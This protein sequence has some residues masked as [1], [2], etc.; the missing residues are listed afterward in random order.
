MAS[1]WRP[2]MSRGAIRGRATCIYNY[3]VPPDPA[4]L[5]LLSLL[6]GDTV[7]IL[8]ETDDWYY[9]HTL[10]SVKGLFPKSYVYFNENDV[11][12]EP[13]VAETNAT[14]KEWY[15]ILKEKF[16]TDDLTTVKEIKGI[17][18]E[19]SS[20][21]SQLATMKLTVEMAKQTREK[22]ITK[23]DFLN[24]SLKLDLVVRDANAV[25]LEPESTSAVS[26]F[27]SHVK[28]ANSCNKFEAV[29]IRHRSKQ[30]N[31]VGTNSFRIMLQMKSFDSPKITED[32]D[33]IIG[34]YDVVSVAG[35]LKVTP[36]CETF[37]I[38]N[39]KKNG[40]NEEKERRV[41]FG[42]L[43]KNDISNLDKNHR[44]FLIC[45]VVSYGNYGKYLGPGVELQ[46]TKNF[47][48]PIGV[49]ASDI[50]G[51]FTFNLGTQQQDKNIDCNFLE[52]DE[53]ETLFTTF[54]RFDSDNKSTKFVPNVLQVQLG[55]FYDSADNSSANEHQFGAGHLL[56]AKKLG[57]PE[58]IF[59]SDVRNDLYINILHGE[60]GR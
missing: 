28:S 41:Q 59:P 36:I 27:R 20:F 33:L 34:I 50:T 21:R 2:M 39:W 45:N 30:E 48:K 3:N 54:K 46:N 35:E 13:L 52:G 22:I 31:S 15:D 8:A 5:S 53:T 38:E 18:G 47:R 25:I 12:Q 44:K 60:L 4:D 56:V 23:T 6:L 26:L 37:V 24:D 42:D 10:T 17:M 7:V 11:E 55:I 16:Q 57:L 43:S 40:R 9:G 58:V 1:Q 51:L 19:V 14:L 32:V 49:A 29:Q